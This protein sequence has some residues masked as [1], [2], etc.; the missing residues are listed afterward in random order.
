MTLSKPYTESELVEVGAAAEFEHGRLFDE[1]TEEGLARVLYMLVARNMRP[2]RGRI[3]ERDLDAMI[4]PM[5]SA[6][7]LGYALAEREQGAGIVRR[8]KA[9]E[10][11]QRP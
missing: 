5:L 11:N 2:R 7:R 4:S 8:I 1:A 9:R 10:S 6:F 3:K